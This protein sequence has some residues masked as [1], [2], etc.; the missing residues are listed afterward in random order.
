MKNNLSPVLTRKFRKLLL[1]ASLTIA[2]SIGNADLANAVVSGSDAD[3]SQAPWQVALV[4]SNAPNNYEGHFCG[5]SLI[6]TR[7]VVTAEHCVDSLSEPDFRIL[8]GVSLLSSETLTGKSVSKIIVHP[9]W[10]PYTNSND[11]ALV[12]I[13]EPIILIPGSIE[14]ISIPS[15]AFAAGLDAKITG[16]G[17]NSKRYRLR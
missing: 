9:D 5:G 14:T 12:E 15:S 8:A 17:V 16:W 3:I 7:W 10:N 4:S 6:S 2:V 11:V 13:A 1:G